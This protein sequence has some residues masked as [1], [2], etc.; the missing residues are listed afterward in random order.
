MHNFIGEVG[1]TSDDATGNPTGDNEGPPSFYLLNNVGRVN[2]IYSATNS[3][4]VTPTHVVN[5]TGE[6]SMTWQ[7]YE[8]GDRIGPMPGS[9]LRST[10]L[11]AEPF[12]I[13]ADDV[14][15]LDNVLLPTV[16]NSQHLDC[17]GNYLLN[18]DSQDTRIIQQYQNRAGG[19]TF[20]GQFTA[21]SIPAGTPCVESLH[22]GIPDAWK[23]KYGLSLT[24]TGMGSRTDPI[25]GLTYLK[26][27]LD[28]LVP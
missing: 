28:G 4:L 19:N 26:D 2:G 22:D 16:G 12:P 11:P 1:N 25:T 10:P 17:N 8:G 13:T 27:Y 6:I 20:F 24:D 21:P 3:N 9:W 5:D 23:T 18:R 14:N 7:R 15:N